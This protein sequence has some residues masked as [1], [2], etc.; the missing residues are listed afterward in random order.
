MTTDAD[1]Y[2]KLLEPFPSSEVHWRVGAT[3]KDKTS[4]IPLAYIDA[5]NVMERLDSVVGWDNWMDEYAETQ[6]GV[7]LCHLSLRING[8][9]ISKTDGA[10]RTDIEGEKG[11]ISDAFKRA[12]VKFG[13][14]RYLYE[15]KNEWVAVRQKGR[16]CVLAVNPQ[17]P[18][19]ALPENERGPGLVGGD[20]KKGKVVAP[21]EFFGDE[22]DD[23]AKILNLL[24]ELEE[25][26]GEDETQSKWQTI[27]KHNTDGAMKLGDVKP[28]EM[29]EVC[30]A[31]S[32]TVEATKKTKEE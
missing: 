21:A 2:K 5:R 23:K 12:A 9:W 20:N 7:V 18:A 4:G 16:T 27:L 17:L 14:G 10:G 11:G 25:L 15:L 13:V 8:E 30:N 3:N 24:K 26:A 28:N 6:S 32:D 22:N 1:I 19:W 29:S 31:L